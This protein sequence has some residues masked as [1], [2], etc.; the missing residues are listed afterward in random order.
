MQNIHP[1]DPGG[2]VDR[3]RA[4]SMKIVGFEITL[5]AIEAVVAV[6][7][8]IGGC[9]KSPLCIHNADTCRRRTTLRIF[10]IEMQMR[11][12]LKIAAFEDGK[13]LKF[14]SGNALDGD[15]RV[16][17]PVGDES[18]TRAVRCPTRV[19]LIPLAVGQWK[20]IAA[21]KRENPQI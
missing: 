11:H 9:I 1:Q 16:A 15:F 6:N 5:P 2:Y 8:D 19:G 7:P 17:H 13:R 10:D 3:L 21:A 20:G 14:A 4:V 18:D 12:G